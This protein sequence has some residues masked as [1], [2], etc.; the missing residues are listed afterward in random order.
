M[1]SE[2]AQQASKALAESG[3]KLRDPGV[4]DRTVADIK[5]GRR[6]APTRQLNPEQRLQLMTAQYNDQVRAGDITPAQYQE[7]ITSLERQYEVETGARTERF[8]KIAAAAG[9][10]ETT[11]QDEARAIAAQQGI[12]LGTIN[13]NQ[14]PSSQNSILGNQNV[15]TVINSQK[16]KREEPK[17]YLHTISLNETLGLNDKTPEQQGPQKQNYH[18]TVSLTEN[19]GGERKVPAGS[20]DFIYG[21]KQQQIKRDSKSNNP[22][23]TFGD[24]LHNT[25]RYYDIVEAGEAKKPEGLGLL[26]YYS[27]QQLKPFYNIPLSLMGERTFPSL[28]ETGFEM[29][30]ELVTKGKTKTHDPI[31]DYIKKDPIGSLVQLPSEALLWITGGKVIEGGIKGTQK[32]FALLPPSVQKQIT[33]SV[34]KNIVDPIQKITPQLKQTKV[35]DTPFWK[36][37]TLD[38]KPVIGIVEKKIVIGTPKP[39]TIPTAKIN[40]TSRSK[41]ELS[42]GVGPERNIF[43]SEKALKYFE[44]IGFINPLSKIRSQASQRLESATQKEGKIIISSL[45]TNAF[46]NVSDDQGMALLKLIE[47]EH[48]AGL[49]EDPHGSLSTRSHI[50]PILRR[51]SGNVI[52][53]GDFD[54]VPK[55]S[56]LARRKI[57]LEDYASKLIKEARDTVPLKKGEQIRIT[58]KIGEARHLELKHSGG[59]DFNKIFEI[60]VKDS[61]EMKLGLNPKSPTHI[62]GFKIPSDSIKMLDYDIR[63]STLKYQ[64]LTQTKTINAFQE[65]KETAKKFESSIIGESKLS[66][67]DTKAKAVIYPGI[68]REQKDIARRYWEG[69]QTE[70]NQLRAGLFKSAKETR[71]AAE[72][73]KK[74]YPEIKFGDIPDEKIALSFKTASSFETTSKTKTIPAISK[75][76]MKLTEKETSSKSD[77]KKSKSK[78]KITT[79]LISSQI[80]SKNIYRN[81]YRDISLV[82]TTSKTSSQTGSKSI[83]RNPYRD[84]FRSATISKT[85]RIEPKLS[86]LISKPQKNEPSLIDTPSITDKPTYGSLIMPPSK[87]PYSPPSSPPNKPPANPPSRGLLPPNRQ[88]DVFNITQTRKKFGIIPI[89]DIRNTTKKAKGLY[90]TPDDFLGNTQISNILGFRTKEKDIDVGIKK[91]SKLYQSQLGK[92]FGKSKLKTKGLI[93]K[94]KSKWSLF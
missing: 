73:F 27:S 26:P 79:S 53:I 62:M 43:Y 46:K 82:K 64:G 1:S 16:V 81:P 71:E 41:G 56:E 42:L 78:I 89:I 76:V 32:A 52:R 11:K 88:Q 57:S 92:E 66:K 13:E 48:K 84:P 63:T 7:R 65:F 60:L 72:E 47:R 80:A 18:Y 19:F 67:L 39:E 30:Y 55:A 35:D 4:L 87:P 31:G 20:L 22:L 91:T 74:L 34:S 25:I 86:G 23:I 14:A 8:G 9:K 59:K 10:S 70:L 54:V 61:D 83:Y 58:D 51:E 93:K 15:N 45:G 68:G 12:A 28:S 3:I 36:G 49:I 21:N 90:K 24:L 29:G 38:N 44:G 75:E 5:S 6:N 40:L 50:E 94:T 77:T 69:R 33:S 17:N 2:K 85:N 37:I